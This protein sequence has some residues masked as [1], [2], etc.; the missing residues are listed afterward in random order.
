[1]SIILIILIQHQSFQTRPTQVKIKR[2][3]GLFFRTRNNLSFLR[4]L[5]LNSVM[6]LEVWAMTLLSRRRRV[7]AN[8]SSWKSSE[9]HCLMTR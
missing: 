8:S 1:M 5:T 7:C 6:E 2:L 9:I 4:S 3:L